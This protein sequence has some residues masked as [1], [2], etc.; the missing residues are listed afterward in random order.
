DQGALR[1]SLEASFGEADTYSRLQDTHPHL[2]A[3]SP[4]FV[5]RE[6]IDQM[7]AVIGAIDRVSQLESFQNH[8]L[9]W[10]PDIAKSSHGPLGV[11]FGYDFH[12]T[13]DGPRLI[14]VNTNA[15]GALL[16]LHVA[17]AQQACCQAVE[18]FVVGRYDIA[19]LETEFVAMFR[20]ELE[21]QSPGTDLRRVAIVDESP[22]EQYL[23]PEF[24]LFK[25]MFAEHGID[26]IITG[27]DEFVLQ[28]GKL[29]VDGDSVDLVYNR[30][31]DF[32]LQSE[33]CNVLSEAYD[34]GAAVFTPSPR[35]HALYANKRTLTVLSD[36]ELLGELG[37]DAATTSVLSRSVPKTR[38]V[39][40]DNANEL[41]SMRRRLFFKPNWG[42]GS[43]GTYKGAK[44]TKK[45]WASILDGDYI[46]QE[47]VPPSE[48]LIIVDGDHQSMKLD[49]RCYVYNGEI[50]LLGARLYRGQTTNFRTGGGGL[51]AVFTTPKF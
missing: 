7:T 10:V 11:F 19:D 35:T 20:R 17:S 21:L 37:V 33:S 9:D 27:P 45:A 34:T 22:T 30:L 15:G 5:S 8:V 46:A 43:R 6:H 24:T 23:S 32:Y 39:T 18:N 49:V 40:A 1:R 47:L 36:E 2:L 28:D 16:L 38:R 25:Q 4:V 3:N 26:A 29:V 50:Q 12:L 48:R 31:T 51:A 13:T 44:L 42:F 14:E 41:W